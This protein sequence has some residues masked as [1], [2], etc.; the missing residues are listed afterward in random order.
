MDY[1]SPFL[2]PAAT[3]LRDRTMNGNDEV[4]DPKSTLQ[5]IGV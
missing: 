3:V 1:L 4:E 5:V 2:L